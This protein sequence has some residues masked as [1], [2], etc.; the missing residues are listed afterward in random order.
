[1]TKSTL[2]KNV[3]IISMVDDQLLKTQDVLIEGT[4]IKTICKNAHTAVKL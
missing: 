4:Q 3:D 1:M 2:I